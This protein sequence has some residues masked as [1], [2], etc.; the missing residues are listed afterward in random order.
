M[1]W[2]ELVHA[3]QPKGPVWVVWNDLWGAK[4]KKFNNFSKLEKYYYDHY[5]EQT[6]WAFYTNYWLAWGDLQKR[7]QQS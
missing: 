1:T 3:G 2:G 7:N 4:L 5:L 6:D